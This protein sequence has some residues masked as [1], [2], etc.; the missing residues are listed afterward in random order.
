MSELPDIHHPTAA[1]LA[2]PTPSKTPLYSHPSSA[3]ADILQNFTPES[4]FPSPLSPGQAH[5]GEMPG[6][7]QMGGPQLSHT[8][9]TQATEANSSKNALSSTTSVS[10]PSNLAVSS[11]KSKDWRGPL[12]MAAQKGHERIVRMLL[13]HVEC[14]EKDPDGQTPLYYAIVG[15]HEGTMTC[16]I[17]HGA[18]LEHLDN[19]DRSALHLAILERRE[20][21]LRR[22]LDHCDGNETLLN[23]SDSSGL[24]PLLTAID[25]GFDA[26]VQLLLQYGANTDNK[27]RKST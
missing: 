20:G 5:S 19:Q 8:T 25:A 7:M 2:L 26:G 16:L 27:A 18:R 21:L 12:H 15:G 9:R 10:P 24:T 6:E 11:Q 14:N 22:L 1:E 13:N 3:S 17:E 23:C 4:M